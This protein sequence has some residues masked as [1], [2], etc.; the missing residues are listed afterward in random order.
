MQGLD[1]EVFRHDF[2]CTESQAY[3]NTGTMGPV[4]SPVMHELLGQWGRWNDEGPGDP[5]R[6][7]SW[8]GRI[9]ATRELLSQ[10]L[11]I[12]EPRQIVFKINVSEA[13]QTVL[14]NFRFPP[15]SHIITTDEEHPAL[16]APL[17][18]LSQEGVPVHIVP[19]GYG[20]VDLLQRVE[21][22]LRMYPVSLVA[23]SHVSHMTGAQ[24]DVTALAELVHH[25]HAALLIDGAQA[26]GHVPLDLAPSVA[27]FYVFNG[28][29]W[30]FAPA[31]CAG[32]SIST[33]ALEY[34]SPHVLGAAQGWRSDYPAG[35]VGSWGEQSVNR[36]ESGTQPWP[37]WVAW[38][39]SLRYLRAIGLEN[40]QRHHHAIASEL[41]K[42]FV[43]IRGI[44]VLS[45]PES[46]SATVT[47]RLDAWPCG[48]LQTALRQRNVI[49]R[50]I[51]GPLNAVRFTCGL[52]NNQADVERAVDGVSALSRKGYSP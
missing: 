28:Q 19:F 2:K 3:F 7:E 40:I 38:G 48:A 11:F 49:V 32:V 52:F 29:K 45:A 10:W 43:G 37:L 4:P 21:D 30:G 23:V 26:F 12:N 9:E 17:M 15:H 8:H 41:Y 20:G 1:P 51:G 5:E 16:I 18:R 36:F 27:D 33:E 42:G 46:L 50:A 25:H 14:G 31:G 13:L 22:L 6:Y 39:H 24:A 47:I 35:I 44:T 34:L